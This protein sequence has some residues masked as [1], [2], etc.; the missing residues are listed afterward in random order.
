MHQNV[1]SDGVFIIAGD[2]N[3]KTVLSRFDQFVM[4]ASRRNNSL[5]TVYS[6]R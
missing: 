3:Q 6:T 5:D 2:F 4:C 1:Y